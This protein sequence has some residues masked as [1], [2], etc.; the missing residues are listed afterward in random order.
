MMGFFAKQQVLYS[1]SHSGYFFLSIVA[2]I[3]SVISAY[4]Y[5]QIIRVIHFDGNN[6]EQQYSDGLNE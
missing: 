5:L 2:I 6:N 3:V 1:A 4:Y